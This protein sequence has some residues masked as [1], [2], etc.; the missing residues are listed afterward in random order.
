MMNNILLVSCNFCHI[1][2]ASNQVK[3]RFNGN[4]EEVAKGKEVYFAAY[5][6]NYFDIPTSNATMSNEE[7]T[8]GKAWPRL[9][10]YPIGFIYFIF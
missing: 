6:Y 4:F 5:L 3:L 1:L 7:I 9:G 8:S 2:Y 10:V